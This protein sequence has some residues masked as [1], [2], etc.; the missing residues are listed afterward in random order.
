M[1][2]A[3]PE[4]G[5]RLQNGKKKWESGVDALRSKRRATGRV[6]ALSPKLLLTAGQNYENG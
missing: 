3:L 6:H 2:L 1:V 4:F 5:T